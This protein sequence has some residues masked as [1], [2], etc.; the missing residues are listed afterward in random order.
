MHQFFLKKPVHQLQFF[1]LEPSN[2]YIFA[3]L[4]DSETGTVKGLFESESRLFPS[5]YESWRKERKI[6]IFEDC[7]LP[8]K[9]TDPPNNYWCPG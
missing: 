5:V 6:D 2:S 1:E 8:R 9:S 7:R 4:E 3:V